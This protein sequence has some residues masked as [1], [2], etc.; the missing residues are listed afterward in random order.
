MQYRGEAYFGV[1]V[2]CFVAWDMVSEMTRVQYAR[3]KPKHRCDQARKSD[4]K[5]YV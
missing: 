4:I 2:S 5:S 3:D 1:G